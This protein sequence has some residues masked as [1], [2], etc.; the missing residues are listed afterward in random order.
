VRK[1][2]VPPYAGRPKIG[3]SDVTSQVFKFGFFGSSEAV[4]NDRTDRSLTV[5]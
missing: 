1:R 5:N 4:S 2:V 3:L